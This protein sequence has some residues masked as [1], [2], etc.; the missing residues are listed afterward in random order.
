MATLGPW[1]GGEPPLHTKFSFFLKKIINLR[2]CGEK[3]SVA[4]MEVKKLDG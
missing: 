1:G 3:A 4:L 2:L